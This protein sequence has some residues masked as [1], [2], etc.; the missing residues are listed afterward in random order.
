MSRAAAGSS[1]YRGVCRPLRGVSIF[2]TGSSPQRGKGEREGGAPGVTLVSVTK[3]YQPHQ[4]AVRDLTLTFHRDQITALLGTNGAGKT[5]VMCVPF[6]PVK[7][8]LPFLNVSL[9]ERPGTG[10]SFLMEGTQGP[11]PGAAVP[12]ADHHPGRLE[13]MPRR[14]VDVKILNSSSIPHK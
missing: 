7:L 8:G 1:R 11:L 12:P 4:A 14:G 5:T 9:P 13:H 2:L 3:E 6:C 10:F